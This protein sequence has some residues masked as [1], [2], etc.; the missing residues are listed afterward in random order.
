[1]RLQVGPYQARGL[2]HYNVTFEVGTGS[3]R[4]VDD[5]GSSAEVTWHECPIVRVFPCKRGAGLFSRHRRGTKDERGEGYLGHLGFEQAVT[6]QSSR[7]IPSQMIA[8]AI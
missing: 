4:D 8:Y 7:D 5:S 2:S 3:I 6:S 1:M